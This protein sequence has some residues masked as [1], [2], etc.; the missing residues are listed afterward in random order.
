MISSGQTLFPSQTAIPVLTPLALASYELVVITV[1]PPPPTTAIGLPRSSG[2]ACCSTEAKKAFISI[3]RMVLV[4]TI[5]PLEVHSGT[6]SGRGYCRPTH[7][8]LRHR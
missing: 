7:R 6:R 4:F 3:W 2:L 1:R 5:A 8:E